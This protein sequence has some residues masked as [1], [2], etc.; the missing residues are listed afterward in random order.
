MF[1]PASSDYKFSIP[2]TIDGGAVWVAGNREKTLFAVLSP[3]SLFIYQANSVYIYGVDISEDSE[4]F[5]IDDRTVYDSNDAKL[6]QAYMLR[7][8][9]PNVSIYLSVLA[10][11]NSIATCVAS[12][13][14]DLFVCLDDGWIHRITWAGDVR[15]E[16]SFNIRNVPL[17]NDQVNAKYTRIGDNKVH[18]VDIVYCPLIGGLCVVLSDGR[19]ALLV[20]ENY[21]FELTSIVGIWTLGLVDAVCCAANHKFRLLYFGCSNGDVAAYHMDDTNGA[22]IQT[23]RVKLAIKDGTEYLSRLGKVRQIQCL[24]QGLVFAVTWESLDFVEQNG[25]E[26]PDSATSSSSSSTLVQSKL[27][28]PPIISF[29]SPFGAQWW[30]S[31]E[32]ASDRLCVENHPYLSVEW[33]SEGFQLWTANMDGLGMINL[34]RSISV[35][36]PSLECFDRVALVSADSIYLSPSR[37]KEKLATAPHCVWSIY[38]PP[39][40]YISVNFPLR[41]AAFDENCEKSLIVAG[42]R[43]FAHLQ[44]KSGKWRLFRNENQE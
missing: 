27:C 39:Q 33:G 7:H 18:V 13:K 44:I 36:Q 3:G 24:P 34:S 38:S 32:D 21:K 25:V 15:Q 17:S 8:R 42:T 30:C 28:L 12:L 4:P 35:N 29:F 23:F 16:L 9:H 19:A 5:N 10:K 20:S 6:A 22:M 1:L 40:E 26:K 11:I 41:F 2:T 37:N 43:G 31:L 14:D